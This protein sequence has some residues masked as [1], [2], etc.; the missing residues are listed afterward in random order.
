MLHAIAAELRAALEQVP[1]G[2]YRWHVRI[3][4]AD[5]LGG[6]GRAHDALHLYERV[7]TEAEQ[8]EDWD[9][10]AWSCCNWAGALVNVGDLQ[11]AQA[12]YVRSA[13]AASMAGRPRVD[14]VAIELEALRI[15]IKHGLAEKALPEIEARLQRIRGWW[16]A[17]V[18]GNDVPE[19][20][21]ALALGKA[22]VSSLDV[23]QDANTALERG[24]E[25]LELV[26]EEERVEKAMGASV[27]ELTYT[28][29]NRCGPLLSLG[30]LDEAQG[31]LE[32]SL[33]VLRRNGDVPGAHRALAGLADVWSQRG[34][35]RH[36][37]EI[38]RQVLAIADRLPDPDGRAIAHNNLAAMLEALGQ[39]DAAA[40]HRIAAMSYAMVSG[41]AEHGPN[42]RGVP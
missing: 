8:A 38:Q 12:A 41:H 25:C 4:M 6:M 23:A 32:G 10:V 13:K 22:M 1:D 42:G 14:V 36:A 24:Q 16:Q 21:D 28:Q 18:E 2:K 15:A 37:I 20:P 40:A 34:D 29:L 9:M 39:T 19:A 17:H 33:E 26:E 27:E 5:A 11:A 30:R 3:Y 35:L 31:L 7:A